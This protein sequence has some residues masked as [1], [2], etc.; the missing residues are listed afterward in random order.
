MGREVSAQDMITNARHLAG[1]E[2]LDEENAFATDAELL[3]HLNNELAEIEDEKL[4]AQDDD[5]SSNVEAFTLEVGQTVYPLQLDAYKITGVDVV[6][7]PSIVRSARR[8]M[9]AERNRF[10]T[11]APAWSHLCPVYYRLVGDNLE[12]IPEPS[13]E[14][15][16]RVKYVPNFTPLTDLLDTYNSQNGWHMA[17]VWGLV[18]YLREKDDDEP[19]AM[20]AQAQKDK[21]LRRIREMAE[22]IDDEPMR[23]QVVRNRP[24]WEDF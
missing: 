7:T 4:K 14:L 12:I 22:R 23:V 1:M 8:F 10:M 11:M 15:E 16:I 20:R 17:A 13:A 19:G 2:T 5:Y 21:Q 24:D 3:A 6:W 18:V 9:N